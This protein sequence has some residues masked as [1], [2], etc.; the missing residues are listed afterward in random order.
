MDTEGERALSHEANAVFRIGEVAS[1]GSPAVDDQEDIAIAIVKASLC[2]ASAIGRHGVDAVRAEVGG[3]VLDDALNFRDHTIQDV[4][5]I[6]GSNARDVGCALKSRESAR[7]ID[8]EEL[9]FLRR[10]RQGQRHDHRTQ[11]GRLT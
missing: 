6:S 4:L 2:T 7:E 11:G 9:N 10:V 3:A 1:Q 5:V 8:D